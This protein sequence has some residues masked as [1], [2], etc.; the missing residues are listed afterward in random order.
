MPLPVDYGT[1]IV[2]GTFTDTNGDP[3]VGTVSFTPSASRLLGTGAVILGESVVVDLDATGSLSVTLPAS[4]DPNV[5]PT[6]FTYRVDETFV[7]TVGST[8]FIDVL[9]GVTL[10]LSDVAVPGV[11]NNGTVIWADAPVGTTVVTE[12]AGEIDIATAAADNPAATYVAV[13]TTAAPGTVDIVLPDPTISPRTMVAVVGNGI[14]PLSDFATF[15]FTSTGS[16]VDAIE[17]D[18]SITVAAVD[19]L[20]YTAGYW[21]TAAITHTGGAG[22]VVGPASA[23]TARIATFSGTT[24]KLLQDGGATLSDVAPIASPTFTGTP[25]APTP[26]AADNST[27]IATTAYVDAADALK[28]SLASPALTGNPT[29]PTQTAGNNST[30]IATT[31][32]VDAKPSA[33]GRVMSAGAINDYWTQPHGGITTGTPS[34][35]RLL[36]VP[37]WVPVG[38]TQVDQIAFEV[39][40]VAATSLA[41]L[42][43]YLPDSNNKPGT[44]IIDGGTVDTSSG[45]GAAGVRTLSITATAVTPDSLIYV[46]YVPQTASAVIRLAASGESLRTLGYPSSLTVDVFRDVSTSSWIEASVSGALPSTATPTLLANMGAGT[47]LVALR[48]SA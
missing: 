5:N 39:T 20:P 43:L 42:G 4:D 40:T 16:V 33:Y 19:C 36:F 46:A 28:A 7:G 22:D 14:D 26:T 32:Y 9:E 3:V 27:K 41:R 37:F 6:D 17:A 12:A 47:P 48:R 24:G 23:V 34:V 13:I 18:T 11:V 35:N 30:R 45:G 21:A 44:R 38:V 25:A 31:A 2:T 1:G 10:D 29:A 15:T 8:Y